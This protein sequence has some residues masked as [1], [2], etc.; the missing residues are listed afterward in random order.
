VLA[1]YP[2]YVRCQAAVEASYRDP[3]DW[4]RRAILNVARMGRFSSY[5]TV[6]DYA[7]EVWGVSA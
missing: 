7:R 4:S 6:R 5:R 3:E 1:D 2:D